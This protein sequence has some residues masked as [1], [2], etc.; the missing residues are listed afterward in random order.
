ML[1]FLSVW[2]NV[3]YIH[4]ATDFQNLNLAKLR[5]SVYSIYALHYMYLYIL[6]VNIGVQISLQELLSVL[7][8]IYLELLL[9]ERRQG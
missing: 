4:Y 1:P 2:F 7:L 9:L 5:L 3:K 6:Y 8:D